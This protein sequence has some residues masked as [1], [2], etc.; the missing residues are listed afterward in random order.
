MKVLLD[1]NLPHKLRGSLAAMSEVEFVTASFIG[2]GSLR[3]GELLAAA[4]AERFDVLVTGDRSLA[5]EQNLK[6]RSIAILALSTNNW[7]ILRERIV[8]IHEAV[9]LMQAGQFSELDCGEFSRKK[10]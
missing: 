5:H 9:L 4:E 10:S 7:P 2:W 6:E 1:H 3:N 8:E